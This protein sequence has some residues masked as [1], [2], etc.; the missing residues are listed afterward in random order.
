MNQPVLLKGFSLIELMVTLAILGVITSIAIPAY[1]GYITTAK[2]TE[3]TNNLAALRLAEEENFLETNSY[4]DGTD[5]GDL[6]T[7]SNGL[8]SATKGNDGFVNFDYVVTLSNGGWSA[9]ATGD[10]AGTST[11]G[12]YI[13]ISN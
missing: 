8:W 12:K 10:R 4:F 3:A 13:T 5:T 11:L 9:T 2:M 7:N 6:A 1:N